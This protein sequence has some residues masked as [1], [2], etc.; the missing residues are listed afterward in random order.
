[1]VESVVDRFEAVVAAHA[2][3]PALTFR[4]GPTWQSLTYG[5]LRERA[6]AIAEQLRSAGVQAGDA[7]VVVARRHPD[8][9]ATFLAALR[10]GGYYVPV[11][12]RDPPAR[13]Q[14]VFDAVRAE[15]LVE[16]S[17]DE[18]PQGDVEQGPRMSRRQF[19]G[20]RQPGRPES[21]NAAAEQPV[22][23]MF[24][25]GSTGRPKGVVVPHRAIVRLVTG[26]DYL[27][28]D[29]GRVF[30]QSIPLAF[31][32]SGLEI[33]GALLHGGNLV[34]FP[35]DMLPSPAGLREVVAAQRVTT[36]CFTAPL[37]HAL[38]DGDVTCMRG[39]EEIVVGGE[40]LSVPHVRRALEALP[41]TQLVNG[42]GPTENGVQSTSYRIPSTLPAAARVPIGVPLRGTEVIV[43]DEQLREQP[44]GVPGELVVLGDGLALG[45]LD[46]SPARGSAFVTLERRGQRQRAYRTGDRGVQLA[47]GNF[48]FLGR[49][50]RQ[51][52]I[53]GHRAEPEEVERVFAGLDGVTACRVV[54]AQ[55]PAGVARLVAYVVLAAGAE[56]AAVSAAAAAQ[57]PSFLVP[58][59]VVVLTALPLGNNGKVDDAA[60]PSPWA[61]A[62][63]K[64]EAAVPSA[65]ATTPAALRRAVQAAWREVLGRDPAGAAGFFE[66]GG[67]SLDAV[68][69]HEQLER[70]SGR[71]LEPT[72]VYEFPTLQRQVEALTK[73]VEGGS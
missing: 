43:V 39:L 67:R 68:R 58:G 33:Y 63:A 51:V 71:A 42:Y 15:V 23:V 20:V 4:R 64:V 34:L 18:G 30:L 48:D 54:V 10:L 29:H 16:P 36:A 53:Q 47:D 65:P 1:M 46:E 69:L 3:R 19:G 73:M 11:D 61:A 9:I 38:V 52:K 56:L 6:A 40:R 72:F 59:Q 13:R 21:G 45:Y 37:F 49:I 25:S 2:D 70:A 8:T 27:R 60:L 35:T 22:Y 5:R 41:G 62:A 14:L 12:P 50:D 32:A 26:Q 44:V 57:L 24:T 55:D 66:A 31:D 7:V 28:F 17:P